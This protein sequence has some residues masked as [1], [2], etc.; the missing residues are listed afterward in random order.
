MATATASASPSIS[1]EGEV[2]SESQDDSNLGAILGSSIPSALAAIV[3]SVMAYLKKSGG[4]DEG[5]CEEC[6]LCKITQNNFPDKD[7]GNEGA[8]QA[9]SAEEL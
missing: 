2:A 5:K 4:G 1:A 7:A 6:T 9:P 8:P 3:G